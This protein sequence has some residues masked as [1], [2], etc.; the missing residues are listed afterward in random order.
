MKQYLLMRNGTAVALVL[1]T[2][3]YLKTIS[4]SNVRRWAFALAVGSAL[5]GLGACGG[6]P[7]APSAGSSRPEIDPELDTDGDALT[8]IEEIE[9]YG[10]SPTVA[11]TD[12]DGFSDREEIFEKAFD[13]ETDNYQFNPLIA[14][15]PDLNIELTTPPDF[16]LV[17]TEGTET[18]Q[19][20]GTEHS[21]SQT[22][23]QTRS[24]GGSNT[25]SVEMTH[26]AGVE[27]GVEHEF[28]AL[29]GTSVSA[30]LSYE[31]SHSTT[32]EKTVTWDESQSEENTKG[33]TRIRETEERQSVDVEGG[34]LVTTVRVENEGDIAYVL[35]N[36]TLTAYVHNPTDPFNLGSVGNLTFID[37]ADV[38]PSTVLEPGERS[39]PLNFA[40]DLDL[41]TV[42]SI[43]DDSQNLVVAPATYLM[44]GNGNVNFELASTNV[45]ARTAQVIVDYGPE[46]E[47]ESYRVA[48]NADHDAPGVRVGKVMQDILRIPYEVGT[49]DWRFAGEKSV[50]QSF[51]GLVRV[52]DE[53]MNAEESSYWIV[54]HTRSLDGG[55]TT[56]TDYHNPILG[57]FDFD[58]IVLKKGHVL[59]LVRVSD[60][61]RDGLGNRSEL[62]YGTDPDDADSDDDGC[63]DSLEISG[64]EIESEGEMVRVFPDPLRP[65]TDFDGM[66]DCQEYEADP[67]TDPVG[68]PPNTAPVVRDLS[69]SAVGGLSAELTAAF[70]EHDPGDAVET[71]FVDW[72]DG[73][74]TQE[75]RVAEGSNGIREVHTYPGVG[76]YEIGV[77]ASDGESESELAT[78]SFEVGVPTDGLLVHYPLNG[79][80][81]DVSGR[82]NHG[83][84]SA[85]AWTS[86]R[87][88][89]AN[90]A[91]YLLN[92]NIRENLGL[93]VAPRLP[94]RPSFTYAVWIKADP[95]IEGARIMGQG[96]WFN[97]YFSS[98]DRVSFGI[99]D[100]WMVDSSHVQIESSEGHVDDVWTL[101]VAVVEQSASGTSLRLY[102][103]E[104][105]DPSMQEVARA[106]VGRFYNNTEACLFFVGNKSMDEN[107]C[108]GSQA[109]R[110]YSFPGSVDDARVYDRALSPLEID[111]LL[112]AP[113]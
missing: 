9:R 101:Y 71:V 45:N 93:V 77:V 91:A 38:F 35:E 64:W 8:D 14:D 52:R 30:S 5:T 28:G 61:D 63:S 57:D 7:S 66:T 36:L 21:Q 12:G 34:A 67:R 27:V 89:G 41:P 112:H 111:T 104:Y 103:G 11:D 78:V 99:L 83:T 75:I 106:D 82:G 26:T 87:F 102:K 33:L 48:T 24:W 76:N 49:S 22:T 110:D 56:E 65:D 40:A 90:R 18:A 73:S 4:L 39:A 19:R 53:A 37:G 107:D 95:Q 13:P 55:A 17:Y 43:L 85:D 50:R 113:E 29:G 46:R 2:M 80:A 25:R 72:G 47:Q 1:V 20:V 70:V 58:S 51:E 86:D 69:V 81:N 32:N 84:Y 94:V 3:K 15:V 62:I 23:A 42:K 60:S 54:A 44:Q 74:P 92:D 16:Y 98:T 68:T 88:G 108:N 6:E 105:G 97:M 79:H 109:H 59:H 31:F 100:G 10:T 96:N